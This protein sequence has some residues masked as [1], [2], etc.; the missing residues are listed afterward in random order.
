[1][2]GALLRW[3]EGPLHPE[4]VVQRKRTPY[5]SLIWKVLGQV[6]V[7]RHHGDGQLLQG[8]A[9]SNHHSSAIFS[10]SWLE[11]NPMVVNAVLNHLW[12]VWMRLCSDTLG[13]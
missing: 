3:L 6:E 8:D 2:L 11:S 13:F 12:I 5:A 4:F 9:L 7:Q 10:V 1:M